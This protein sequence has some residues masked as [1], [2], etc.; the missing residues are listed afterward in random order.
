MD[1]SGRVPFGRGGVSGGTPGCTTR[2]E[3]AVKRLPYRSFFIAFARM[4]SRKPLVKMFPSGASAPPP[5]CMIDESGPLFN[6]IVS[7][8]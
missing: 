6:L 1:D 7:D 2:R 3:N 4:G 8:Y 5:I